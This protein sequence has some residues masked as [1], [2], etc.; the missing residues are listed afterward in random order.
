V[1]KS[2]VQFDDAR[3]GPGRYRL[4]ETVRRYAAGQLDAQGPAVADTARTVHRDYYLALA[5]AAAPQLIAHDQMQWMDRLDAELG[6]LRAA[7]ALSLAQ[8]DPEPGLRLAASLRVYWSARG[9]AA[10]AADAL[11]ALL[12]MPGVQRTMLARSRT[13]AAAATLA[14]RAG[15]YAAAEDYCQEALAIA[16]PPG[17]DYLVADL[18]HQ[19]AWIL[20]HQG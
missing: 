6:N 13:L 18:L 20:L 14:E 8:A 3:A 1:D 9:H 11:R 17:E 15:S 10:E 12:D 4:L 5:E 2:L 7:I 19:R 16:A